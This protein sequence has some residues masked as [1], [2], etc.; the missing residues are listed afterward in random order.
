MELPKLRRL[1]EAFLNH[2]CCSHLCFGSPR[3]NDSVL[4]AKCWQPVL[5][6]LYRHQERTMVQLKCFVMTACYEAWQYEGP[7]SFLCYSVLAYA[8]SWRTEIFADPPTPSLWHSS[9][10]LLAGAPSRPF[11]R[12]LPALPPPLPDGGWGVAVAAAAAEERH[13]QRHRQG[14]EEPPPQRPA[15]ARRHRHS[16]AGEAGRAAGPF[17]GGP[18]RGPFV[19]SFLPARPPRRREPA[20]SPSLPPLRRQPPGCGRAPRVSGRRGCA[21]GEQLRLP[22]EPPVLCVR[23][24]IRS[25]VITAPAR[26]GTSLASVSARPGAPAARW[27]RVAGG[28]RAEGVSPWA[29]LCRSRV[30]FAGLVRRGVWRCGTAPRGRGWHRGPGPAGCVRFVVGPGG[31]GDPCGLWLPRQPPQRAHRSWKRCFV[32][33][34]QSDNETVVPVKIDI[35]VTFFNKIGVFS[36]DK[37]FSFE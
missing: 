10:P 30:N 11:R 9:K 19:R 13:G 23:A 15:P 24:K 4:S 31:R 12:R 17:P 16:A 7:V 22:D 32:S 29:R 21:G 5:F 18:S 3:M 35:L 27:G 25:A 33:V 20:A 28:L 14:A 34:L 2:V 37:M 6:L 8:L 36:E 26:P 1:A